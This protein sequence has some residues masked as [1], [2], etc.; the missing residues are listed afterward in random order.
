MESERQ[1]V[2]CLKCGATAAQRPRAPEDEL[3]YLCPNCR[4]A[5]LAEP[6]VF[7]G[8]RIVRRLK[9]GGMGAV[10]LALNADGQKVALKVILPKAAMDKQARVRFVREA[11]IHRKLKHPRIVQVY[12]VLQEIRPAIFL[13]SMEYV[14]GLDAFA[15]LKRHGGRLEPATAVR[16]TTQMLEGLHFA[17]QEG[18]V[19]RDI[20]PGNLLVGE[21]GCKLTDFGLAKNY[22][23]HCLTVTLPG[24][25]GGTLDYL[26][27][28][29]IRDF[30]GVTPPADLYS[31]GALL[32][33]FLTGGF[34]HQ[35]KNPMKLIRA[36]Q[37][38]PIVPIVVRN[39][40]V[41]KPL[42]VA[43]EKALEKDPGKRYA[44]AD[45]M[46]LALLDAIA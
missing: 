9:E 29:Q 41:P 20:K 12:Q 3:A 25:V 46:R 18:V 4:A 31:A 6:V 11:S 2:A 26:A 22:Q 8:H 42:A 37:Y 7:P 19:H 30:R 40:A 17:H 16:L 36:I 34:P 21:D 14:E 35:A 44:S 5:V 33:L 28:E 38:D 13:M 32:Y 45:E 39:P 43:V 10:Y 1:P 24:D 15:L 27:P 23:A